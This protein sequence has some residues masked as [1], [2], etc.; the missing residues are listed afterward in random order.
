MRG[1]VAS[2]ILILA[3]A[4][5]ALPLDHEPLHGV[6]LDNFPLMVRRDP[7]SNAVTEHLHRLQRMFFL[8]VATSRTL[9]ELVFTLPWTQWIKRARS[10]RVRK[11]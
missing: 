11:L 8:Q 6:A 3:I 4:A 9:L 1:M 5:S 2:F 10:E 7:D